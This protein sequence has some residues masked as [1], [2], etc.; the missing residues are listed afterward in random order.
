MEILVHRSIIS[1]GPLDTQK[2]KKDHNNNKEKKTLQKKGQNE[3]ATVVSIFS[4]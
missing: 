4:I 1:H 2:R 3:C